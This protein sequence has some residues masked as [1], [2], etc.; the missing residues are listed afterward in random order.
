[1]T[2]RIDLLSS[3]DILPYSMLALGAALIAAAEIWFIIHAFRGG[4]T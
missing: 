4:L 2:P 3:A 1:M